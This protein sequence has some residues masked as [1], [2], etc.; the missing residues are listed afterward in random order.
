[1]P[2][3]N[4]PYSQFNFTVDIQDSDADPATVAGGFQEVSGIGLEVNMVEYRNGNFPD[5][6]VIIVPGLAKTSDVTCKR[7]IFGSDVL[8]KW[9]D[10]I[11]RGT[12]D[13]GRHVKVSLLSEDRQDVVHTWTLRNARISKYTSGPFSAKGNDVA[14]E[15]MVLKCEQVLMDSGQ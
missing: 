5:N 13:A 14:M 3:R 7:G 2:T 4:L 12:R 9:L 10:A 15:E 1:M 6:N 11:R 8:Y